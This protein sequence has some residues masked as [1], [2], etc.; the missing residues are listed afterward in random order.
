MVPELYHPVLDC[1][2]RGLSHLYR[3]VHAADGTVLAV[4]VSGECGGV[5]YLCRE[6]EG[7]RLAL[8]AAGEPRAHVIIPQ[9]IAWRVFT[10]G[11]DRQSA[12]SQITMHGDSRLGDR[13]LELTAVVG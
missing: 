6:P 2:L 5:W 7:W 8:Q 12:R 11:I 1:F 4:E 9:E 13:V 3:D 10:K